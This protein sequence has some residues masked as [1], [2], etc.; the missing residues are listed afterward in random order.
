MYRIAQQFAR[1]QKAKAIITGE[2]LGQVASQTLSNMYVLSS[3]IELPI[4][5]PVVGLDKVEIE[6]IARNIGTYLI[7]AKS[8][9]GCK[10]VPKRPATRCKIEVVEELEAELDLPALIKEA[11]D[12]IEIV[13]ER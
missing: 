10:A 3:A 12:Q 9:D 2:S 13:A 8:T 4:L 6:N 11:A 1:D 5:R 7:T